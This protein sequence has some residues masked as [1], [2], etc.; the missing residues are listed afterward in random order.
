MQWIWNRPWGN[1]GRACLTC[2]P[3]DRDSRDQGSE[4]SRVQ[5]N[6][7]KNKRSKIKIKVIKSINYK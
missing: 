2:L 6:K 1:K 3:A 4:G 5:E 7:M